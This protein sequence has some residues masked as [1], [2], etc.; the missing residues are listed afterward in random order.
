[1]YT[2][3]GNCGSF[4]ATYFYQSSEAPQ[5]RRGHY[6][7]FAMSLAT[8]VLAF[9]D[10]L[11]LGRVNRARDEGDGKVREGESVGVSEMADE[12]LDFR[13]II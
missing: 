7:Y 6:L 1:M 13:F 12:S 11:P 4:A 9:R 8:A 3:I 10:H 5:F 2:A